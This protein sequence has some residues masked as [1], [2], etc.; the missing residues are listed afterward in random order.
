MKLSIRV[1]ASGLTSNYID[2]IWTLEFMENRDPST[3]HIKLGEDGDNYLALDRYPSRHA[4]T[5]LREYMNKFKTLEWIPG[6]LQSGTYEGDSYARLYVENGWPD[7]FDLETFEDARVQWEIDVEKRWE[8]EDVFA[9]V[10]HR[11]WDIKRAKYMIDECHK[12]LAEVDKGEAMEGQGDLAEYRKVV[13]DEL[14]VGIEML[15]ESKEELL[16]A[17]DNLNDVDTMVRKMREERI[18]K[19]GF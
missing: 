15:K 11:E 6:G 14:K 10:I 16:V 12:K 8:N 19:Y 5:V 1:L 4:T 17:K 13:E 18:E 9:Q 2:K 7:N 3:Q